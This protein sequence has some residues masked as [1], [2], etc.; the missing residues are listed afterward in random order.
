[1]TNENLELKMNELKKIGTKMLI[2]G[3]A[4]ATVLAIAGNYFGNELYDCVS[5]FQN[6]NLGSQTVKTLSTAIG[7]GVGFFLGTASVLPKMYRTMKK[8]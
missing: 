1:M 4:G 6:Y 2:R 8:L 5:Y 7:G 3:L